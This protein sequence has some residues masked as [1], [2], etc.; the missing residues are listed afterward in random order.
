MS[1]R[2][3]ALLAQALIIGGGVVVKA[4]VQAYQRVA[5]NPEA[6]K[7]AAEAAKK[8]SGFLKNEM[9]A[10]EAQQIL[11]F[12]KKPKSFKE[13]NERFDRYFQANDPNKGGSFYLQ[14]K[15]FR[16]KEALEKSMKSEGIKDDDVSLPISFP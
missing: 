2:I 5:A 15:I 10:R 12:E 14:S 7:A 6:A 3:A 4:F 13:L 16:A 1:G 11:N 9:T 8:S